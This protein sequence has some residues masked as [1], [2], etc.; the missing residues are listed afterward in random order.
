MIVGIEQ[1]VRSPVNAYVHIMYRTR[2]LTYNTALSYLFHTHFIPILLELRIH[3]LGMP[4][5]A[6]FHI[7]TANPALHA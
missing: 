7:A 3:S 5:Q 4:S 2:L 6:S 1:L